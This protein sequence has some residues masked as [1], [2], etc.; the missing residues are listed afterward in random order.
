MTMPYCVSH[1]SEPVAVLLSE[2][3]R[4]YPEYH[5]A[6]H[7]NGSTAFRTIA[8]CAIESGLNECVLLGNI[9]LARLHTPGVK[10]F[11]DTWAVNNGSTIRIY[12]LDTD[13]LLMVLPVQ[14]RKGK[15]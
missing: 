11:G 1:I 9:R 14:K 6:E 5:E 4:Q 7:T 2:L 13:E 10:E 12:D 15:Q 8:E 3:K